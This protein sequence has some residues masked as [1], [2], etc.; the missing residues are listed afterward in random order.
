MKTKLV[1]LL[2]VATIASA[3]DFPTLGKKYT[4]DYNPANAGVLTG[5]KTMTLVYAFDYWNATT[6]SERTATSAFASVIDPDPTRVHRVEM[7]KQRQMWTAEIEIPLNVALLSYYCTDGNRRDY[8]NNN[9]YVKYVCDKQGQPVR[10]ARFRNITFLLMAQKG[11]NV[12]LKEISTELKNF[13][14]NYIAY[15]PYWL[16]RID[17]TNSTKSLQIIIKE[18]RDEFA[19]LEQKLGPTDSLKNIKA[20]VIYRYAL[21]LQADGTGSVEPI[22][23]EF[24]EIVEGI[25]P[26]RRFRYIQEIYSEWFGNK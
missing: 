15:I 20:G 9:T 10:N 17:T 13:P 1:F 18:V 24:K 12:Q 23:K 5:A 26:S 3:Q 6:T 8:N 7:K 2:A 21:K 25:P 14:D 16:L 22:V 11:T 19:S 4:I